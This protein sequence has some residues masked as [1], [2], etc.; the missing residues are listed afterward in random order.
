MGDGIELLMLPGPQPGA[1]IRT[2]GDG[3]RA[4]ASWSLSPRPNTHALSWGLSELRF[5]GLS[6]VFTLSPANRRYAVSISD[7]YFPQ[8]SNCRWVRLRYWRVVT[9][10]M[11]QAKFRW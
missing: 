4:A 2:H 3:N 6:P 1:A 10:L 7:G 11:F 9:C 8:R 5:T